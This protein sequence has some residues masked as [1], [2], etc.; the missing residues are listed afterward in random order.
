MKHKFHP[1][2]ISNRQHS[3]C[4]I[5]ARRAFLGIMALLP[6]LVFALPASAS[7]TL[8]TPIPAK[9]LY[10][11]SGSMYPG[12]TP[13]VSNRTALNVGFVH[14]NAGFKAWLKRFVA[15]LPSCNANKVSIEAFKEKSVRI[16]LLPETP[17][18]RAN[19][20]Q[21]MQ[22]FDAYIAQN[23]I[24][25]HTFL[26]EQLEQAAANFEGLL[27]F[28][29]DNVIDTNNSPE[30]SD[31][32]RLF[33]SI[34][35]SPRFRAVFMFKLPVAD[36]SQKLN[37]AVYGFLVSK[38]ELAPD[39]LAGLDERMRRMSQQFEGGEYVKFKDLSVNPV[40]LERDIN[41]TP[42]ESNRSGL[43]TENHTIRLER[44]WKIVSKLTQHSIERASC[45][46]SFA[47][48][49]VPDEKSVR[50][51]GVK[52]I[53]SKTFGNI[54]SEVAPPE[55]PPREERQIT[56]QVRSTHDIS[57]TPKSF[58]YGLKL[59]WAG[60]VVEYS[61]MATVRLSGVQLKLVPQR[62]SNIYG[63][64]Q[65]AEI[66][67]F[68]QTVALGD[69]APLHIPVTFKVTTGAGRA[70]PL[71]AGLLLLI[72]GGCALTWFVLRKELCH[73]RYEGTSDSVALM[74]MGGQTLM[75]SGIVLGRLSRGIGGDWQFSPDASK[76][77]VAIQPTATVGKY[78]VNIKANPQAEARSFTFSLEPVKGR[79]ISA[80]AGRG[81]G[82]G[83]GRPGGGT[84]QGGNTGTGAKAGPRPLR[85]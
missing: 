30:V 24:G 2:A 15:Q 79:L 47:Q 66:F 1:I 64:N 69:I 41:I 38:A 80:A 73:I 74:R 55:I 33:M 72:A 8:D 13:G 19:T 23:G 57:I 67:G 85:K 10:D 26:E 45:S 61:G 68:E 12:Y 31:V 5:A 25:Q 78:A 56:T 9:I 71:V 4:K 46:I 70:L 39:A 76:A 65:A 3:I 75:H 40:S 37:V 48:P 49:F 21:A 18:E 81:D 16:P 54:V 82:R 63:I 84:G 51:F 62:L 59:A 83:A 28:I 36:G 14:Q 44:G 52:S 27:W 58:L 53:A 35:N 11:G 17:I 43:F 7:I 42:V 50:Q 22:K 60:A 32:K 34:R 29:T 20:D 77:A 6:M